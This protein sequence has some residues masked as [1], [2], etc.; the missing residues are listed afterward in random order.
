VT[1]ISNRPRQWIVRDS[2]LLDI[3]VTRPGTLAELG[4]IQDLAES[5]V[6]RAGKKLLEIIDTATHDKSNYKPPAR[7][8]EREKSLLKKMQQ[9]VSEAAE[10]LGIATEIVAPKKELSAAL[11]GERRSRVFRGWRREI[12]GD[13]LTELLDNR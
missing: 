1:A 2:V 7:P 10:S 11:L 6:R 3:A 5:T 13:A 9:V 4:D 12:V 8:G